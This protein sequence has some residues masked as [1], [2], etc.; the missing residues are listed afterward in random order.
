MSSDSCGT[1]NIWSAVLQCVQ[2][3]KCAFVC[4]NAGKSHYVDYLDPAVSDALSVC[5]TILNF[6]LPLWCFTAQ[7]ILAQE[8]VSHSPSLPTC[9]SIMAH[10]QV[11]FRHDVKPDGMT[12]I[13]L[14][15]GSVCHSH[16]HTR[17]RTHAHA[18]AHTQA[19]SWEPIYHRWGAYCHRQ[20][21]GEEEEG[22]GGG[23]R[24]C[25]RY[26]RGGRETFSKPGW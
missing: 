1:Q 12:L 21:G 2:Y 9:Q 18:H 4:I 7:N 8:E 10:Q 14:M 19:S 13:W 22:G 17:A 11:S 24:F 15:K 20:R 6:M 26:E 3:S 5:T 16:T 23:G 25:A